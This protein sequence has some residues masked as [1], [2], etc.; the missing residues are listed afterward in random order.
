MR[1]KIL[2]LVLLA[3]SAAAHAFINHDD[4][5]MFYSVVFFA[6]GAYEFILGEIKQ[7]KAN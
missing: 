2:A 4:T 6:L 3:L 5:A 7:R 1:D